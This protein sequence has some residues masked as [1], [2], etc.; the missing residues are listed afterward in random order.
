MSVEV[1]VITNSLNVN[2]IVSLLNAIALMQESSWW[3]W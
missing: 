3:T 2:V 1:F